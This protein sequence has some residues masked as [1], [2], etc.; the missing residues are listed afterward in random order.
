MDLEHPHI[1]RLYESFEDDRS[2]YLVLEYIQGETL[3]DDVICQGQ[4]CEVQCA[5]VMGQILAALVYL[6]GCRVMHRDV[7][8]ENV[9]VVRKACQPVTSLSQSVVKLIDFGLAVEC[10]LGE[11]RYSRVGTKNYAAPEIQTGRYNM[12]VDIWSVGVMLHVLLVHQ[13]P[14]AP[15]YMYQGCDYSSNL[16]HIALWDGVSESAK[17]LV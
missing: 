13:F 1:C 12:S 17:A 8:P 7:K 6:H 11:M 4:V 16:F 3:F 15:D 5:S 14:G 9:M 2:I 10:S